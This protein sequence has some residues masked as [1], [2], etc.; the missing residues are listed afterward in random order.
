MRMSQSR[1]WILPTVV[2]A[3]LCSAAIAL[4]TV[5]VGH[6]EFHWAEWTQS[7]RSLPAIAEAFKSIYLVGW[8]LPITTAVFGVLLLTRKIAS[9]VAVAFWV[10]ALA[11]A[12]VFWL[13]FAFLSIYLTNQS[14]I[15]A[16]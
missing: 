16:N 15:A 10:S 1:N 5:S 9:A 12:H 13:L 6:L 4:V 8:L 14:F 3:V 7:P 2:G 11:V